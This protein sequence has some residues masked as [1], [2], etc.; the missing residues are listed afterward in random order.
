MRVRRQPAGLALPAFAR[1][2]AAPDRELAVDAHPELVALLQD[3]IDRLGIVRVDGDGEAKPAGQP[4]LANIDPFIAAVVAAVH[5]A[6]VLLE[7]HIRLAGM[8]IQ[9]VHA[10]PE[11]GELHL[12]IKID[13]RVFIAR[14]P[15]LPAVIAAVY[16]CRGNRHLH[17][18]W[19][20]GIEHDRVQA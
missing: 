10:L 20:A 11:F 19:V 16:P 2:P 8:H 6:V 5:P 15:A 9:L 12:P 4:A 3:D 13:P 14:L 7:E 18:L 17:A 1:V